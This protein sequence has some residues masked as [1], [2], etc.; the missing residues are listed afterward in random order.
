MISL[1]GLIAHLGHTSLRG[2]HTR[3][4]VPETLLLVGFHGKGLDDLDAV[5]GLAQTG[6]QGAMTS[7][8]CPWFASWTCSANAS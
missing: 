7:T 1:T 5:E 6:I 2:A 4:R 8:L 3:D